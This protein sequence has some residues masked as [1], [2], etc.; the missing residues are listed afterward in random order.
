MF[1]S[2]ALDISLPNANEAKRALTNLVEKI[3]SENQRNESIQL[4]AHH[5]GEMGDLVKDFNSGSIQVPEFKQSLL[6]IFNKV[7][8]GSIHAS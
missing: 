2:L 3:N 5:I 6:N 1:I 4:A 8:E 7:T